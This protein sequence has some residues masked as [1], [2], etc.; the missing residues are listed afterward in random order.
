MIPYFKEFQYLQK[1]PLASFTE[2]AS[3]LGITDKTAKAHYNILVSEGYIGKKVGNKAGLESVQARICVDSIG[4]KTYSVFVES[5]KLSNIK[6]LEKLAD[7]H[8]FTSYRNRVIGSRQGLFLQFN[9]PQSAYRYLEDLF[10][11]LMKLNIIDSFN[12]LPSLDYHHSNFPD[13]TFYDNDK[14]EWVWQ[15]EDGKINLGS[16][17]KHFLTMSF[18]NNYQPHQCKNVM[19]KLTEIDLLLLRQLT[20]D[21]REFSKIELANKFSVSPATITRRIKFL[22]DNVIKEYRLGY[23]RAK[24]QFVD[25]I[26]FRAYCS[27]EV[28]FKLYKLLHDSP[29]PFD[30]GFVLLE[31]GFLWRLNLPPVYTSAFSNLLWGICDKLEYYHL[32]HIHSMLY[33]FYHKNFDTETKSWKAGKEEVFDQPIEWV[34]KNITQI[35]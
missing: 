29:V 12:T 34:E 16:W 2:I 31:D 23:R 14:G 24:V 11:E 8:N 30:S 1:N 6:F 32:D 3:A 5:N 22:N 13:F 26:M 17:F 18:E 9:I 15:I 25:L 28:K 20:K 19:E 10:T 27:D 33:W 7:F 4:L 35:L 21:A